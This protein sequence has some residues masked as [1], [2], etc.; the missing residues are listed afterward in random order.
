MVLSLIVMATWLVGTDLAQAKTL[1]ALGMDNVC[2]ADDVAAEP[3]SEKPQLSSTNWQAA[4][5]SADAKKLTDVATTVAVKTAAKLG[6]DKVTTSHIIQL[7]A[8]AFRSVHAKE[9]EQIRKGVLMPIEKGRGYSPEELDAHQASIDAFNAEFVAPVLRDNFSFYIEV[10]RSRAK[11]NADTKIDPASV[12][13]L[14]STVEGHRQAINALLK[15]YAPA[16]VA[17]LGLIPE[18]KSP[19]A[20]QISYREGYIVEFRLQRPDG[21]KTV[22][23]PR[24]LLNQLMD[25]DEFF[26]QGMDQWLKYAQDQLANVPA[27]DAETLKLYQETVAQAKLDVQGA[28]D[29]HQ[30]LETLT[31]D[32]VYSLLDLFRQLNQGNIPKCQGVLDALRDT[33]KTMMGATKVG[34][35]WKGGAA[36]S[37]ELGPVK[38]KAVDDFAKDEVFFQD[39]YDIYSRASAAAFKRDLSKH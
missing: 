22:V 11:Q 34:R 13:K 39:M 15:Q 5:Q 16:I 7:L 6:R 10:V 20:L 25:E 9:A 1:S 21:A 19:T 24:M 28:K 8:E 18:S 38:K 12:A 14:M 29:V 36:S 30:R 3:S 32:D 4:F 37:S 27:D 23:Y 2:S 33:F 31:N 17:K 35:E 26:L